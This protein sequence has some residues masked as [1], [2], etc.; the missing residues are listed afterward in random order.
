VGRRPHRTVRLN[1]WHHLRVPHR[2]RLR[3]RRAASPATRSASSRTARA[4]DATMQALA[5][6]FNLRRPPSSCP[7]RRPRARAHLH[8]LVR[9]A[10][11]GPS[12]A[13]HRARRAR[14]QGAATSSK[15]E[16][17]AG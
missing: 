9:D 3:P 2:Q 17:K 14:P 11:R 10:V 16:M 5:R 13:R 15:L 8:A 6:Q 7:R 4:S 1:Q 12:D